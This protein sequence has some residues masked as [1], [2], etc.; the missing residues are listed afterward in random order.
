MF[1]LHFIYYFMTSS[2]TR[3][4][5][6]IWCDK[7]KRP[8]VSKGEFPRW[9]RWGVWS[10]C[11]LLP[12]TSARGTSQRLQSVQRTWWSR[13]FLGNRQNRKQRS[14]FISWKRD[15]KRRR[16][17]ICYKYD[18]S[19][20]KHKKKQSLQRYWSNH[21]CNLNIPTSTISFHKYC[22]I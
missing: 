21:Y 19:T 20:L 18:S 12:R 4:T 22:H 9:T 3:A 1:I 16:R 10:V 11:S 7:A 5:E 6:R 13:S 8:Q 15:K 14:G 17:P 2:L